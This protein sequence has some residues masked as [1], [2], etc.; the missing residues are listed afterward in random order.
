MCL[1][2][3]ADVLHAAASK[4][5]SPG[6]LQSVH[7]FPLHRGPRVDKEWWQNCIEAQLQGDAA[8]KRQQC[9]VQVRT[10]GTHQSRR[11][12]QAWKLVAPWVWWRCFHAVAAPCPAT[13]PPV[14]PCPCDVLLLQLLAWKVRL[15]C[16]EQGCKSPLTAL[17]PIN[18]ISL[19]ALYRCRQRALV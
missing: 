17:M 12:L 15:R 10:Q 18:A 5:P 1:Q 13:N 6:L 9:G 19:K 7:V 3:I 16:R 11:D 8:S 4:Q 14:P 2:D